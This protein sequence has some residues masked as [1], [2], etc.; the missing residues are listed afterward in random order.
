MLVVF[1]ISLLP[2]PKSGH[3]GNIP[4][5]ICVCV[6]VCVHVYIQTFTC[7]FISTYTEIHQFPPIPN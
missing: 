1:R 5:Y 6:C 7:I 4:V 2:D 3:L